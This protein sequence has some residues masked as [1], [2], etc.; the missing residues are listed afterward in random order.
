VSA[1]RTPA[2]QEIL[3]SKG[4]L[5]FGPFEANLDTG[6]FSKHGVRL[7][8]H[9]QPF[10]VLAMLVA[11]PG[12]LVTRDEMQKRLWPNGTFVDF[13]NG[14]NSAMNRL[15]DALGDSADAPRFIETIPRRG[16]R[17]LVPVHREQVR[18]E[19]AASESAVGSAGLGSSSSEKWRTWSLRFAAAAGIFA[20][21]ALIPSGVWRREGGSAPA[22]E[23]LDIQKLT[24]VPLVT[25]AN[26]GQWLPAFSPDG[27]RVAYS[28]QTGTGWYLEVK[29]LGS[30]TRLRLTK[31][32]A[33]FPPGPTWSPDGR[34]I[35][36]VRADTDDDRG[37][38]VTSAMGGAER[39]LR[40]LS[41]WRVPQRMV[42]WS[43][44]GRWIAFADEIA[45]G[46]APSGKVRGPNALFLIS[47]GTL[48]TRQ[49]TNPAADEF[50]DSAPIFSPDGS[51][52]AFVHTNAQSRDEICTI[53]VRGGKPQTL[54]KEGLWTNGLAWSA[55]GKS[56]VFD[57]SLAGGFSLWKVAAAGGKAERLEVP[58]NGA[59]LL[60][61]NVW[62]DR[63]AYESHMTVETV[64]RVPLNRSRTELPQM[65]VA[66][67]RSDSTG[68]FSVRGD[69]MAFLS[70]RT[71]TDELWVADS[72]GANAFQLT[73]F[74][75]APLSDI[76]WGPDGKSIAVSS[77]AGKVFLVSADTG[78]SHLVYAGL[79]FTDENAS[80][81]AFARD[82][83][84]IYISSQPGTGEKYELLKVLVTGGA[85]TKV[86]DGI[87]TN[88]AESPDGR[89]LFYSRADSLTDRRG[90]G[91]WKCPTE[92]G[93]EKR[94]APASSVWDVSQDGLYLTSGNSTIERYSFTGKHL[95]TVAKLGQ[96]QVR[97]PM[98]VSPDGKWAMFG[99]QQ[100][101][102]T[103]IDM[104]Q[105]LK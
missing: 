30:E 71:G 36:F 75:G 46:S 86:L 84:S 64:G 91:I 56:I 28:W 63:L 74:G 29:Q 54:V 57:R 92:G 65:P 35:A 76:A 104:V 94:I 89:W 77:Q 7:K 60:E 17:F 4:R 11:R 1:A 66:S 48:E 20:A 15:R 34:Q 16:Y 45:I 70:N 13:E 69:R 49:L 18:S 90:T 59:N 81:L 22:A 58:A 44:D 55:D 98:S 32:G 101:M 61:P 26:G 47:P 41:A 37:I 93:A 14:L 67:T 9:D 51:T 10:E 97:W 50:G 105:G 53:A 25:Y 62:R 5:R 42:S 82:G 2:I 83:K 88:F 99:Y 23:S 21:I 96:Y 38:F 100:R 78:S 103:E 79:P 31:H 73:H 52:I 39:K 27:S 85:A 8:L 80:N 68:R 3:K 19:K 24:A 95:G 33:K 72:D 40:T 102:T 6:E 43:P 87:F 12:E